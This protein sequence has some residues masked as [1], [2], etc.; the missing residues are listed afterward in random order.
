MSSLDA[1]EDIRSLGR[2]SYATVRLV[3][4][5]DT[6]E[7]LVI[8]RFHVPLGELSTRERTEIYQEIK[9][10][11]HLKHPNIVQFHSSFVEHGVMHIVMVSGHG[12]GWARWLVRVPPTG[13]H[14]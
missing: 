3:R 6:G 4:R 2:G 1:Y 12:W 13:N 10:L 5:L 9:L 8:K 14:W 7:L 11:A